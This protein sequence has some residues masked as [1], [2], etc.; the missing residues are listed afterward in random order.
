MCARRAF[1]LTRVRACVCVRVY[2]CVCVLSR[3]PPPWRVPYALLATDWA[4]CG[5]WYAL[6]PRHL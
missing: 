1:G 6:L 2:A 5:S 3:P 4:K